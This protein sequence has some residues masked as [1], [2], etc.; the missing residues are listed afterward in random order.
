MLGP[1]ANRARYPHSILLGRIAT[2]VVPT[3]AVTITAAVLL[4]PGTT[5]KAA[6]V[7]I[8]G[9]PLT[10]MTR[11]ALRVE[12]AERLYGV[13]GLAQFENLQ[14]EAR[15]G[16]QDLEARTVSLG[17]DGI[18][19]VL[20]ESSK[21]LVGPVE[22]HV[23]RGKTELAGAIVQLRPPPDKPRQLTP[24]E[25]PG[26]D[27]G[28]YRIRVSVPKG[29]VVADK[30][31]ELQLQ[32]TVAEHVSPSQNMFP[33]RIFARAPGATLVADDVRTDENG[34]ATLMINPYVHH[35]ELTLHVGASTSNDTW[36]GTLPIVP[37]ATSLTTNP[38]VLIFSPPAARKYVYVSL[39]RD[40]GRLFGAVLREENST[41][42]L[43]NKL[44]P[45]DILRA[46]TQVIVSGDPQ[47]QGV[48]TI[49][50][51]LQ[52]G[53]TVFAAPTIELLADGGHA[54]EVRER[55]RALRVRKLALLV[56]ITTAI[57]EV[58]FMILKSRQSQRRFERNLLGF[59]ENEPSR[60]HG[61]P[62][63]IDTR[64]EILASARQESPVLRVALAVSL[65]LVAFSM[66]GA[67]STLQW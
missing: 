31:N 1:D 9:T 35:V 3:L 55:D 62:M 39:A 36:E 7:R 26:R 6:F 40:T 28:N 41:F 17:E 59:V 66:I 16:D 67:L 8:Y 5:R 52:T 12:G 27:V 37:G 53:A 57:F 32:V 65:V 18:G 61:E 43:P 24:F 54:A 38:G 15:D 13:D 10:G 23:R 47:E 64:S 20:L 33:A 51:P 60:Q 50:W 48:G 21:P 49:A 45:E 11:L 46:A 22:L 42:L 25:V 30:S 63:S 44:V 19:E 14:V 2:Y 34:A 58:L 29:A 4:G 56:V